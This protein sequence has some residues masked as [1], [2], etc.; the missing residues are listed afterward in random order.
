MLCTLQLYN[1]TYNCLVTIVTSCVNNLK[2]LKN[3]Y[4]ESSLLSNKVEHLCS[5]LLDKL[6]TF[7]HIFRTSYCLF[8]P[9]FSNKLRKTI[10]KL[11]FPITTNYNSFPIILFI[12]KRIISHQRGF[13]YRFFLRWSLVLRTN[14]I[15]YN[16][17]M[18]IQILFNESRSIC[19]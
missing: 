14:A 5:T 6:T 7:K 19:R 17:R 1:Y 12:F 16:R 2:N 11:I 18:W 9:K 4:T 8:I 3:S 13:Y 10:V 15:V